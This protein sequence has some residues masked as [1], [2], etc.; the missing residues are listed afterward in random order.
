[1]EGSHRVMTTR[2]R[3]S[4]AQPANSYLDQCD[5]TQGETTA[6]IDTQRI[7]SRVRYRGSG[8]EPA[9]LSGVFSCGEADEGGVRGSRQEEVDGDRTRPKDPAGEVLGKRIEERDGQA[10]G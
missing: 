6:V 1:V 10:A 2:G 8:L 3:R 7:E 5:V 4:P 9:V